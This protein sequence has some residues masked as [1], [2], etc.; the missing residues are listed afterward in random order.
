M[1][2][3]SG[4]THLTQKRQG[5][6]TSNE[7]PLFRILG[8]KNG[9]KREKSTIFEDGESGYWRR[10]CQSEALSDPYQ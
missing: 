7:G 9:R 5:N 6:E 2:F 8:A 10:A 4:D 1:R 3:E